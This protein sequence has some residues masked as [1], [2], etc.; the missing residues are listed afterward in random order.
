MVAATSI[1]IELKHFNVNDD[2]YMLDINS[3]SFTQ[4]KLVCTVELLQMQS[5]YLWKKNGM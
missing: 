4:T 1:K 3:T 5:V 2:A